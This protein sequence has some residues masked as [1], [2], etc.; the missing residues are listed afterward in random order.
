MEE[1]DKLIKDA[2]SEKIIAAAEKIATQ[3]GE[4]TVRKI[5][6]ELGVTN[7][8]FYNRFHNV[9]EVLEIVYNNTVSKIRES[10][11]TEYDG[12]RDFFEYVTDAVTETLVLSYDLKMKFNRYVFEYDSLSQSNYTWYMERIKKLFAYAKERG[13]VRPDIDAETL[14]YAIWCFCRGYNADAVERNLPKDEAVEKFRYSFSILLDG[15]K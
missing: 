6:R 2:T 8:V 9:D 13:I 4:V 15:L 5:L 14:S 1:K 12:K 7:R 10:M 3:S 11:A